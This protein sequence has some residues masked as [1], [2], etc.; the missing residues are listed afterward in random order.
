M[1]DL[2]LWLND[3]ESGSF[4]TGEDRL[5]RSSLCQRLTVKHSVVLRVHPR[6]CFGEEKSS[7]RHQQEGLDDDYHQETPVGRQVLPQPARCG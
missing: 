4:I 5:T 6:A 3:V 7:P 2:D 1:V